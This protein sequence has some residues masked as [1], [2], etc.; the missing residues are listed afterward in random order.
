ML[1]DNRLVSNTVA[2]LDDII[3]D[4]E[5]YDAYIEALVTDSDLFDRAA[6]AADELEFYVYNGVLLKSDE[7]DVNVKFSENLII[8]TNDKK[9]IEGKVD[10]KTGDSTYYVY[11]WVN[12]KTQYVEVV[13][14]EELQFLYQ[15]QFHNNL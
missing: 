6:L 3:F 12:G 2:N 8:P 10:L 4:G 14:D 1:Q 13:L 15:K 9:V 5:G 7:V 11:A